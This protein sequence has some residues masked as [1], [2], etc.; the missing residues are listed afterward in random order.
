METVTPL[1]K[2]KSCFVC[3]SPCVECHHVFHGSY[4]KNADKYGMMVW[5]CPAHHR[6][7]EGVHGRDGHALDIQLKEYAQRYFETNLGTREDF[8]E[9]FGKSYL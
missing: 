8:R 2:D 6:G 1:Q 4:R 9:L 7:T 5:L 3:G